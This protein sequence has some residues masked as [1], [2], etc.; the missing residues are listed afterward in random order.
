MMQRDPARPRPEWLAAAAQRAGSLARGLVARVDAALGYPHLRRR[1][2]RRVGYAPDFDN[3]RSFNE[4]INW[5]KLHDRASVY[6]VISD[7]AR[8]PEYLALRF[9]AERAAALV[10][11]RRL[12][13]A[14]PTAANLAAAGTGVAIKASHGS[15]WV[16]IVA[17]GESPDWRALAAEARGWLRQVYGQTR[18]EWAYWRI[19]PQIV[20]EELILK[21]DGAPA[22]DIKIAVMQG[23]A[24][25]LFVE[26]DRFSAHRLSYYTPDWQPL[27]V[28]MGRNPVGSHRPPPARL[29]EMVALAEE[30]GR[31]FDYIRV[32][33]LDGAGG[34]RVNEL[35]LYRSSGLA[36]IDPPELDWQWGEAWRHRPYRG[37]WPEDRR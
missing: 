10:P 13:T 29:A 17:A 5:R 22:D 35:T 32:D 14:R 33:L 37:I 26:A 12:V 16:R 30:I 18:Q 36:A 34:F 25:Y 21:A 19:T 8:M 31:D 4:K 3:P 15:G 23:R 20:V 9:G 1:F 24:V 27:E 2:R 28:A 6:P 7:K 11:P